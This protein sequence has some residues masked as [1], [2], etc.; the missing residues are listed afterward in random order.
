[1]HGLNAGKSHVLY[2]GSQMP[3]QSDFTICLIRMFPRQRLLP[4]MLKA[5][6]HIPAAPRISRID[7]ISGPYP[8][9]WLSA[10]SRENVPKNSEFDVQWTRRCESPLQR[11]AEEKLHGCVD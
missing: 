1:M 8:R 7:Y 3:E 5:E 4:L 6:G 10:G 11:G 2:G 9:Q